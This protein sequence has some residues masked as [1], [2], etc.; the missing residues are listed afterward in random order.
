MLI[1]KLKS[2]QMETVRIIANEA[3]YLK[4]QLT[5]AGPLFFLGIFLVLMLLF[6]YLYLHQRKK[7]KI[8]EKRTELVKGLLCNFQPAA[9]VEKMAGAFI[10]IIRSL[11]EAGDYYF[12]ILD[13][14]S[15]QFMLKTARR[16][17]GDE[18]NIR[19]DY[20]GLLPYKKED[21]TP[22]LALPAELQPDTVSLVKDGEVPLLVLPVRGGQALLRIGP[23]KSIRDKT[24][25]DLEYLLQICQPLIEIVLDLEKL[26]AQVEVQETSSKAVQNVTNA[27]MDFKS[28][29]EMLM[30]L[31][32]HMIG[33]SGG[34]FIIRDEAN[35]TIPFIRGLAEDIEALFRKDAEGQTLLDEMLASEDFRSLVKGEKDFYQL[36]SY[37]A[38]AGIE[39]LILVRIVAHSG[40]AIAAF[41]YKEMP[42]VELHRFTVLQMMKKRMADLLDNHQWLKGLSQSY[43]EML[44]MLVQTVDNL[45]P[46]TVGYS[47]LMGRYAEIIAR[48]MRLDQ[49]EI[50]DIV[51]A[52]SLSN[53]G[54][55]GFSNQ[56]LFKTGQYTE[57]EFE[58]MKLH[59]SI[60]AS[61]VEA[62]IANHN[63]ASY[64]RHHHERMD[65]NGYP[66]GLKGEEIPLGARIIA[67]VQTFLAKINGRKYR[68]PLPYGKAIEL[69]KAAS[70]TQLD[71]EVV[72]VLINWFK[73]K[74][75]NPARKGRSLGSCWEM[76]CA[77]SSI[78]QPCPAY[79]RTDVNCWE[80][81]GTL[82]EAHGN[83]CETC[84][85]YTEFLYRMGP[86]KSFIAG[87]R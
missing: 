40:R 1:D 37:Y 8:L 14:K 11:V 76:R 56:L 72:N 34:C 23:V 27:A 54:L 19:P 86:G 58:T 57:A 78:C 38:A 63:V 83:K 53:V 42:Q 48:E 39:L 49:Q 28:V 62:T 64:I 13:Q 87:V 67:V 21:Y 22:P 4:T 74:Q 59:A 69:L 50:N 71:G 47:E 18:P 65:G 20:S 6:L 70:H 75:A 41:W 17:V 29:L 35:P 36:P 61:I 80:V 85:V 5:K 55:L 25:S 82:C 43:T 33:A 51:L 45:E 9:G 60:G 46:Y 68:D 81:E 73:K 66:A 26:Q 24:R 2:L 44:K 10:A 52:A 30:N 77:P 16:A 32:I 7:V 31:S 84:L 79:Q 15:N 3:Q 12:Y